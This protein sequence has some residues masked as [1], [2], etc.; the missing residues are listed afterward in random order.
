MVELRVCAPSVL[1]GGQGR[2]QDGLPCAIVA[3]EPPAV[4]GGQGDYC[5]LDEE[6]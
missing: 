2:A 6:D 5:S 4:D 1:R 3:W